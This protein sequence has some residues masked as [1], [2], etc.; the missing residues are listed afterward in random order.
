M[1][2]YQTVT[3]YGYERDAEGNAIQSHYIRELDLPVNGYW[4]DCLTQRGAS[5][6]ISFVRA[7]LHNLPDKL[8][9]DISHEDVIYLEDEKGSWGEIRFWAMR[10]V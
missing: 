6:V 8:M 9:A 1:T 10:E 5:Q 4:H 2:T 7:W 3:I